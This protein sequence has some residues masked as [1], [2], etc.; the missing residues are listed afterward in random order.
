[1]SLIGQPVGL[2]HIW[3]Y[4]NHFRSLFKKMIALYA[5]I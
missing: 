1:M 2:A 5:F 4:Y 3:N